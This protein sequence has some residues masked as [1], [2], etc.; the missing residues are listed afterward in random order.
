MIICVN[1]NLIGQNRR[2]LTIKAEVET[3]RLQAPVTIGIILS[4][5]T[6]YHPN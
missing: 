5:G 6:A 4:N 1:L 2:V 3:T